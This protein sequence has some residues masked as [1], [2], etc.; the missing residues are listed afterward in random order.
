MQ[1]VYQGDTYQH[2]AHATSNSFWNIQLPN[3]GCR[4]VGVQMRMQSNRNLFAAHCNLKGQN[5]QMCIAYYRTEEEAA[6][7][8]DK[9]CIYQVYSLMIT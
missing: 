8:H 1:T 2:E 6:E 4:F 7:M 9:A 3:H 5:K